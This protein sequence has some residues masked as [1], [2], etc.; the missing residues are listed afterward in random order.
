M[1]G[2]PGDRT[3]ENC[4]EEVPRLDRSGGK[5]AFRLPEAKWDHFVVRWTLRPV[6]FGVEQALRP[7]QP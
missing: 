5:G 3:M 2:R 1:T 7:P 4:L 6:I